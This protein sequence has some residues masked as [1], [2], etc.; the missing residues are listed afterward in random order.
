MWFKEDVGLC[1]GYLR[2]FTVYFTLLR[3]LYG[4]LIHTNV[5]LVDKEH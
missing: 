2:M 1:E 5:T 4:P 3:R